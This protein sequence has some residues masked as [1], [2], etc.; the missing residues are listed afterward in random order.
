M[1]ELRRTSLAR[2]RGDDNS[3]VFAN[4]RG[5]S[6]PSRKREESSISATVFNAFPSK[7]RWNPKLRR[8]P[9]GSSLP[10]SNHK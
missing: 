6:F 7:K 3:I 4:Q 2:L 10:H 9:S 1:D 5:L 8:R